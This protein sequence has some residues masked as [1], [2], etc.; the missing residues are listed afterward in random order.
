MYKQVNHPDGYALDYVKRLSDNAFIPFDDA[1]TDFA[2]YKK[3]LA[4]GNV[5]TPADQP[6][7]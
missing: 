3:W 5:P 1:N 7:E 2:E 4:E 6:T